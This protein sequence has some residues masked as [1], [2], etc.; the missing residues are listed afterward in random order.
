MVRTR[1]RQK[2]H[3][4]Q[5]PGPAPAPHGRPW[6]II[7]LAL[8]L[9]AA[10]AGAAGYFWLGSGDAEPEAEAPPKL[11]PPQPP[12]PAPEGMVWVRGGE[13]YRGCEDFPDSQPI[14]KVYVD[15]FW[16]DKTEV[17]NAQFAQFVKE[18]R[19]VTLAERKPDATGYLR[20]PKEPLPEKPFSYVFVPGRFAPRPDDPH[21]MPWWQPVEGASWQ[22]PEGPDSDLKGRDNHPVVHV[23]W[24]DVKDYCAWRSKKTGLAVRLP[25]EAEWEF[26][27][28][29]GLDRKLFVWGD[30]E[31]PGGKYMANYW[32]G[33]FPG[34]S[35]SLD[36][37]A[38]TAP[39]GSFPPNGY[40]LYD[41]AGNV[42]DLCSDFYRLDYYKDSPPRNPKGPL[43]SFD[44]NWPGERRHVM[45]GGSFLCGNSFCRKYLPGARHG[46]EHNTGTS[47]IGFRCVASPRQKSG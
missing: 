20:D 6:L 45:R 27:A 33:S 22:H 13:F 10:T 9:V 38:G 41:M 18:T 30:E 4:P 15:G 11:N 37:F 28:R 1:K 2:Q 47:H 39:A 40:G 34:G 42:W 3:T 35:T 17:T 36:G 46:S 7:L 5:A 14:R 21:W 12:G 32:Q 25:T 23:C 31:T 8:A 44:P 43:S 26:A 24:H 16:M 19:Y 29:G